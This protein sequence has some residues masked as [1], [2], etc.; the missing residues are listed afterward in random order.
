MA[1]YVLVLSLLGG[2]LVDI[3]AAPK[4]SRSQDVDSIGK[5]NLFRPG[6]CQVDLGDKKFL[7]NDI[8]GVTCTFDLDCPKPQKCCPN[9]CGGTMCTEPFVEDPC[10]S[11]TCTG[12]GEICRVNEL[13]RGVCECNAE[14]PQVYQPICGSDGRYYDNRCKL[15]F[16][17]CKRKRHIVEDEC[18]EKA[19][20]GLDT[21][22]VFETVTKIIEIEDVKFIDEVNIK[23]TTEIIAATTEK[24]S[25]SEATTPEQIR[26]EFTGLQLAVP[27]FQVVQINEGEDARLFCDAISLTQTPTYIW[28]YHR[29][30]E[31]KL[32]SPGNHKDKLAVS[33]DGHYLTI[34][35]VSDKELGIY[36]CM[37]KTS[38]AF[39]TA[40][41]Q[42]Q[43]TVLPP[44]TSEHPP[45]TTKPPGPPNKGLI[46][47]GQHGQG[48]PPLRENNTPNDEICSLPMDPGNCFRRDNFP[49]WYY[50]LATQ[51]CR[52]FT[53]TGCGGNDNRF[54][55]YSECASACPVLPVDS[56][57]HPIVTGPCRAHFV[58]WAYD[59]TSR[60]CVQFVFGGCGK[61][62]NNFET[63]EECASTCV[64]K[65]DKKEG[66][67]CIEPNFVDS[68]CSS[69]FVL[70][71]HVK[72]KM[73][74]PGFGALLA[75][76]VEEMIVSGNIT[77]TDVTYLN[78]PLVVIRDVAQDA[79]QC[80]DAKADGKLYIFMGYI[81]ED[82]YAQVDDTSYV[83]TSSEKRLSKLNNLKKKLRDDV[84]NP[85]AWVFYIG[86]IARVL[87]GAGG[88]TNLNYHDGPYPTLWRPHAATAWVHHSFI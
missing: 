27:E 15:D 82:G 81:N 44:T 42:V 76:E 61:N 46:P 56:C 59:E 77:T 31:P 29:N 24:M 75:V 26:E 16:K 53:Y 33:D 55:T 14:C 49:K 88:S 57:K 1:S 28:L 52:P 35:G 12:Q 80:H 84:L 39:I 65:D 64:D 78:G 86:S 85:R 5:E 45:T 34:S 8:C 22:D 43:F 69:H 37:V 58:R 51:Q 6:A 41:Y 18:Q 63:N 40:R 54:I 50:D 70:T 25:T 47:S 17:A 68:F 62:G 66:C 48:K 79:C 10:A 74:S 73:L 21:L 87:G 9:I 7:S 4:M 83:K 20:E 3:E 67:L 38:G 71:G 19:T 2:L 36:T 32:M 11:V 23:L 13:G 72:Q 30:G 60:D